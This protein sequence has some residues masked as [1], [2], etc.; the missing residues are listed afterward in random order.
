MQKNVFVMEII[1]KIKITLSCEQIY[2]KK[3]SLPPEDEP[4][5]LQL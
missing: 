1:T 3:L 5:P 2:G 4:H